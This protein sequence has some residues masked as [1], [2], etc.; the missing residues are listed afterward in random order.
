MNSKIIKS[1]GKENNNLSNEESNIKE[2]ESGE[3][4]IFEKERIYN[5]LNFENKDNSGPTKIKDEDSKNSNENKNIKINNN[6]NKISII[7][8]KKK[9]NNAKLNFDYFSEN[10]ENI[11]NQ[12][13]IIN[14][15]NYINIRQY[16]NGKQKTNV[17]YSPS[18]FFNYGSSAIIDT[19]IFYTPLINNIY[20]NNKNKIQN[21]TLNEEKLKKK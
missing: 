6:L 9:M 11:D 19:G 18:Y 5:N 1:K 3:I 16:G 4:K 7:A 13:Y 15:M 14:P 10:K 17:E 8:P 21:L 2:K 12:S 20:D